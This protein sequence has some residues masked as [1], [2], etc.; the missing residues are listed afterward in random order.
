MLQMDEAG[1]K[2]SHVATTIITLVLA[3]KHG[4]G[5]KRKAST[6]PNWKG[7]AHAGGSSS[8]SKGKANFDVPTVSEPKEA[9]CFQ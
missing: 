7:K 5:K 8:G 1:M 6:Q 3:I 2:N 9:T 4:K